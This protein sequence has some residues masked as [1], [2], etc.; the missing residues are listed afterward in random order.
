MALATPARLSPATKPAAA[1]IRKRSDHER[2]NLI[3]AKPTSAPAKRDIEFHVGITKA[4]PM[5]E[6]L[7][8][9]RAQRP[10]RVRSRTASAKPSVPAINIAGAAPVG[11]LENPRCRTSATAFHVATAAAG[12]SGVMSVATG[13]DTR[14][15]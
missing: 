14:I 2:E 13:S 15:K 12:H 8:N 4:S 10:G 3:A 1:V 11:K 7:G 9:Q 6:A 5:A